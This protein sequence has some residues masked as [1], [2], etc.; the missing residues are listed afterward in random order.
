MIRLDPPAAV[1]GH[2]ANLCAWCFH[3]LELDG[4][5]AAA[6]TG[7]AQGGATRSAH[8]P[9]DDALRYSDEFDDPAK[10]LAVLTK[11][12]LEGIVG[13]K[14]GKNLGWIKVKSQAWREAN[15]ERWELFQVK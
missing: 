11:L 8:R 5:H 4:R 1:S 12:G 10:L 7:R 14:S 3:L 2:R 9:D 13:H 6:A 15:R